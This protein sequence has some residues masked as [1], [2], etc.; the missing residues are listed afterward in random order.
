MGLHNHTS[1]RRLF[2]L[3]PNHD[4][5][6]NY[7]QEALVAEEVKHGSTSFGISSKRIGSSLSLNRHPWP[8]GVL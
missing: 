4:V 5:E 7:G 2:Y 1:A 8:F 3:D 6:A